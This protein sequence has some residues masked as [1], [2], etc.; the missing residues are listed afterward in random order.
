[1]QNGDEYGDEFNELANILYT[2]RDELLSSYD[3]I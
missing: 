1:M 2:H 3:I